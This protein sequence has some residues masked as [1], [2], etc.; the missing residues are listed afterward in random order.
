M[1]RRPSLRLRLAALWFVAST[2]GFAA[3]AVDPHYDGL[4]RQG[5][6]A[7]ERGDAATAAKLLRLDC[8]GLLDEPLL[9]ADCL[10]RLGVAQARSEDGSG[11]AETFRRL[12]E[13]EARDNSYSRGRITAELKD[14]FEEAAARLVP[15][16]ALVDAP[17]FRHL[18]VRSEELE[19]R[20][21]SPARRREELGRRI[22]AEPGNGRWKLLAAETAIVEG[23]WGEATDW[24]SKALGEV[25]TPREVSDGHCLRGFA[26]AQDRKCAEAVTDLA[27]CA[28]VRTTVEPAR[29]F[30]GCWI[31][32]GRFGDATELVNA[33]PG[34]IREDRQI[35]AL[36]RRIPAVSPAP[37][38]TA[39][40]VTAPA[41]PPAKTP[42]PVPTPEPP[43]P[44]PAPS[45]AE[46]P[47]PSPVAPPAKTESSPP[48][49]PENELPA[50]ETAKLEQA[51]KLLGEARRRGDLDEPFRLAR[52]VADTRAS[53]RE[54]QFLVAAI[55]YRSSRWAEAVRYFRRG[56]EPDSA[57]MLFYLAVSLYETGDPEGAASALRRS[58]PGLERT[59]FVDGYVT[60]IL[61]GTSRPPGP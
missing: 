54:A 41:G 51:R 49:A 12:S 35:E 36:R 21:L 59:P 6:Y 29:A 31:E 45:A 37:T 33:L 28:D 58:L 48:P 60:K 10:V 4:L 46:T 57:E 61:P 20:R 50:A 52:E 17:A 3:A 39:P 14:S 7:L 24:A 55:A 23:R 11:F 22:A 2:A 5:S 19:V 13:I 38:A 32:L 30:L 44:A 56:G 18:A 27:N 34:A 42:P 43:P 15:R 47:S 16:S 40:P 25:K 9:L 53:H 1:T 26:L 8:F